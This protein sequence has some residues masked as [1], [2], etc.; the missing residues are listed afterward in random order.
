MRVCLYQCEGAFLDVGKNLAAIEQVARIASLQGAQIVV[1]PELFLCGY[2]VGDDAARVADTVD[3]DSVKRAAEI[4][5]QNQVALIYGYAEREGE[6]LYNAA[7]FIDNSGSVL[8]NYRKVHLF[9]AEEKRIFKSGESILVVPYAGFK[10][11]LLICYDIEFPEFVR[12]TVLQD[13]DFLA[14]PT[15]LTPPYHE[16]PTTIVRARA[17][18]NQVFVA[19]CDRIGTE[20]ELSYIGL[21]GIVGPDGKD[22]VRAGEEDE[23]IIGADLEYSRYQ[24][25]RE[26]NTYIRDRR[27]DLYGAIAR[28]NA[29]SPADRIAPNIGRVSS[30]V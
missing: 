28:L 10:I 23:T 20:R 25:S 29:E 8:G 13:A 24:A 4:A 22:M 11:G 3:G 1:F 30:E 19:Y 5:Q 14:V 15:A 18:E 6:S 16:I 17:Y 26:E 9:G 12:M 27:P 21:S 7:I 2:N